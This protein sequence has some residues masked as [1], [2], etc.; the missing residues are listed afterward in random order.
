MVSRIE[1]IRA[2]LTSNDEIVLRHSLHLASEC[3]KEEMER[4]KA[5][6][7]RATAI[8]ATLV[9]FT[10][11]TAPFMDIIQSES[12]STR[13]FFCLT[14]IA[15]LLFLVKGIYY[16]VKTLGVSMRYRLEPSTVYEFQ[17]LKLNDCLRNHIS[18]IIGVY[19]KAIQPNTN[20]LFWLNRSQRNCI[21]AVFFYVFFVVALFFLNEKLLIPIQ[22]CSIYIL[23]FLSVVLFVAFLFS[24]KLFERFSIWHS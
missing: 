10:G 15:F 18:E 24:D 1:E 4:C 14:F 19:E 3:F 11:F 7:T 6:E 22:S 17:S 13:P 12:E 20:K 21:I 16:A 9:I 2:K 8:L 23:S 5:A